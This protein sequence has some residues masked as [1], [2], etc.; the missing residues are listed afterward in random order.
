MRSPLTERQNQVYEF[1]R[2]Y[3]RDHHMPPTHAEIGRALAIRSS[4]GVHK[5]LK[6]LESKGYLHRT[7]RAARG[8]TLLDDELALEE[9]PP[10]LPL[11]GRAR[12][13]NPESLRRRPSGALYVDPRLL[14]RADPDA[15]LLARAGDDGM[16]GTGL[17]KG[18]LLV[19]EEVEW[20]AL[21]NGETV[22]VLLGELL[23]ARRFD[24]ANGRLHFRPSDRSYSEDVCPPDDPDCYVIGRILSVMRKL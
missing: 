8:I 5:L 21:K 6:A 18:D 12:S 13:S 22:A 1:L 7:P 4:N 11:A 15:C 2:A 16:V 24:V 9:G 20:R 14:G 17:Y 23:V 19:I 10:L 3:L